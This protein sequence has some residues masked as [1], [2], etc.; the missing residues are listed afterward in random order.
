MN[1][2]VRKLALALLLALA[3][4]SVALTTLAGASG[5]TAQRTIRFADAGMI[6]EVNQT[7][8]DAGFQI[9]ADAE[10][11]RKFEVF[12]PDGTRII[13]FRGEGTVRDWGLTELF[14]ESNEPPFDEV[15]LEEFKDR[16]PE[17]EYRFRGE[18]VEGDR[19]VGKATFTHDIPRGAI[20][21]SPEK[22]SRVESDDLVVRWRPAQQPAGVKI[23]EYQVI[24]S[25][26]RE[27][28]VFLPASA[29]KVE[30]PEEFLEPDARYE[31]EILAIEEGG[32]QTITAIGPFRTK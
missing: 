2:R 3:A 19:L 28:S 23:V 24:I 4:S 13:N 7:D 29:R 14:S 16:F 26:E 25:G 17:G 8:G 27:F 5:G 22:G 10:P 6:I 18:T 12:A 31:G 1:S 20:V 30:I 11:W 32:N 15:P 21:L 9:S